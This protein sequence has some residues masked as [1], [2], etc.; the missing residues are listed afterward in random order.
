MKKNRTLIVLSVL[1]I[2]FPIVLSVFCP[3]PAAAAPRIAFSNASFDF[4]QI[5]QNK[6]VTHVFTFQNTGDQAL[7]I[8][9]VKT[10]CGCTAAVL[11]QKTINPGETGQ[12]KVTFNSAHRKGKQQKVIYV[13]SN[14]PVNP[15]TQITIE[16]L[17]KVDLEAT[18]ANVYFNR[19]AKD[20]DAT[21]EVVLKNIGQESMSILSIETTPA[22]AV[23]A[24]AASEQTKLPASLK[25]NESLTIIV[26]A[27]AMDNSSLT[28]GQVV[29][30]TDSKTTPE[31]VISV[32]LSITGDSA[33]E[34]K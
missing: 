8:E 30:K 20:Q 16:A 5:Y 28:S 2:S 11:S 19:A 7:N 23:T 14:D 12:I 33:A 24:K 32:V 15:I 6:A 27:K 4:G 10:S 26:S 1:L 13:H 17:V 25:P 18:P 22:A 29:V 3:A 34:R 9:Q 21:Q 31:V